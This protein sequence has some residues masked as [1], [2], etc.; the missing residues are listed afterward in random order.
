[1]GFTPVNVLTTS[2]S[3]DFILLLPFVLNGLLRWYWPLLV[4]ID[5][6]I[7]VVLQTVRG[8]S[9]NTELTEVGLL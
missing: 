4:D 2:G 7:S 3:F 5:V 6:K 1:M 9:E 8:N